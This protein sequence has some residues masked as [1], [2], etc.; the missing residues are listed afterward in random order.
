MSYLSIGH[1]GLDPGKVH[2]SLPGRMFRFLPGHFLTQV[3]T[4]LRPGEP[5]GLPPH[6]ARPADG[7]VFAGPG[8]NRHAQRGE[9][10]ALSVNKLPPRL[11]ADRRQ[12]QGLDHLDLRG[13]HDLHYTYATLLE[14]AS[15]P[16][17]VID[18]LMGH[19]GGEREGSPMGRIYTGN[20]ARDAGQSGRGD[21][22]PARDRSRR[23]PDV[24]RRR[25][26]RTSHQKGMR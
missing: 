2:A 22:G 16:S 4:E 21:R 19:S 7:R 15:I 1:P 5:L 6:R 23:G 13:P 8:G 12:R 9:R 14:E 11:Y 26:S 10:T 18:E 17:R 25:L 24:A 3:S 20:H